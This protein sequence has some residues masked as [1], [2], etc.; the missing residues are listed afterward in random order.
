[1][2]SKELFV[3]TM[4][5]LQDLN[6]KMENIDA[7]F[8]ALSSDFCGFYISD[9]FYIIID[10]LEAVMEDKYDSLIY[11]IYEKDWL[12]DYELGDIEDNGVPVKIENWE[13]VYDFIVSEE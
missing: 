3:Q 10:L 4:T 8:S 9:I 5:Q 1:M 6:E 13:D 2:I 7:A 11:F 12:R